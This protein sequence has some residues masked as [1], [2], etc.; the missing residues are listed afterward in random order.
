[1][2]GMYPIPGTP[3]FLMA[4]G[5]NCGGGDNAYGDIWKVNLETHGPGEW[6]TRWPAGMPPVPTD[7]M[8]PVSPLSPPVHRQHEL[9]GAAVVAFV[10]GARSLA[11]AHRMAVLRH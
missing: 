5:F 4:G 8:L 10:A 7:P 1:M 6:E 2:A 11:Q 3:D 9:L